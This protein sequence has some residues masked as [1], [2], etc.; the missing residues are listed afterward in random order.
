MTT[1]ESVVDADTGD[2]LIAATEFTKPKEEIA[3][4]VKNR[5]FSAYPS[6][7]L[8]LLGGILFLASGAVLLRMDL[9]LLGLIPFS[10]TGY[11]FLSERRLISGMRVRPLRGVAWPP[12]E[13][14]KVGTPITIPVELENALPFTLGILRMEIRTCPGFASQGRIIRRL[15][16]N[17]KIR[18][19]VELLPTRP[20][21]AFFYG[22]SVIITS[23]LGFRPRRYYLLLPISL[24]VSP[25]LPTSARNRRRDDLKMYDRRPVPSFDGDFAYL[26]DYIPGDPFKAV[27]KAASLKKRKP[28]VRLSYPLKKEKW[29]L[30]IDLSPALFRG[31][32]GFAPFDSIA[33]VLPFVIRKLKKFEHEV[34]VLLY[35]ESILEYLP[36]VLPSEIVSRLARYRYQCNSEQV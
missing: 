32:P 22:L 8:L 20:G 33:G 18:V 30:F 27:V 24:M 14:A 15:G 10:I 23:P 16:P 26:R 19:D 9:V 5:L 28:I 36:K 11:A 35:R 31:L 21:P 2:G 13:H 4:H 34:S 29:C 1:A 25:G 12:M 7:T 17:S 6:P 3:P